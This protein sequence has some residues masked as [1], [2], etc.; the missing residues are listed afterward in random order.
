MKGKKIAILGVGRSGLAVARAAASM[1]SEVVVFDERPRESLKNVEALAGIEELGYQ[2]EFDWDG[3]PAD[4]GAELLVVNPA[5]DHRNPRLGAAIEAGIEVLSEVEFAYR[6]S[7]APIVAITGTNGKST[8]SVMTYLSLKACG[9]DAKLCG[10]IYG[11]G[12]DEMPLTEAALGSKGDQVLVAEVSSF[13]LEWVKL[14]HPHVA[15]ITNVTP[16]H[17]DRYDNFEQY[18]A[19]KHRIFSKQSLDDYAIVHANDT[20]AKPWAKGPALLSYG[21]CGEHARAARGYLTVGDR[22]ISLA[23]LPFAEPH[24]RENACAAALLTVAALRRRSGVRGGM[25]L[26]APPEIFD[27]LKAYSGL[28]HRMEFVGERD[29][30][31]IVNNSMCTNPAA[32]VSSAQALR[33]R[34][35]LLVGGDAKGL[36]F[37]GFGEYLAS[38]D[39]EAYLYG[40]DATAIQASLTRE[41]LIFKTMEEA[42]RAAVDAAKPG[43][44]VML[45]PGC[46]STDQ[47][48]DF[49]ERGDVFKNVAKEWLAR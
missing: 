6:I 42:F 34:T 7:Q 24:N 39:S 10:N 15:T 38:A 36:D 17:L 29:G 33:G 25:R 41:A 19:T 13:Q 12:Y 20:E 1:G 35:H 11:S 9:I 47:F 37:T 8:T 3:A 4:S 27:G 5:V 48:R 46:A 31:R 26:T 22:S 44:T 23:A 30:V 2:V 28:S 14:F 40:Q 32:L 21:D 43:E 49:R 45:A 18:S 16:D